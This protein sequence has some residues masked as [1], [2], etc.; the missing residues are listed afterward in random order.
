M[1]GLLILVGCVVLCGFGRLLKFLLHLDPMG[2]LLNNIASN[3]F[4]PKYQP[5]I[6]CCS[7]LDLKKKSAY[8]YNMPVISLINRATF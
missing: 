3:P 1:V 5:S 2:L 4:G 7:Y 6:A 8:C